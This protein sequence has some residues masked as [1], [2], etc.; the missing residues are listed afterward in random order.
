MAHPALFSTNCGFTKGERESGPVGGRDLRADSA[1]AGV[2]DPAG[3]RAAGRRH[4]GRVGGGGGQGRL[5]DSAGEISIDSKPTMDQCRGLCA[6]QNIG[7][8][9]LNPFI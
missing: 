1:A 3:G 7:S 9:K 8:E 4:R 2:H 6:S 5:A